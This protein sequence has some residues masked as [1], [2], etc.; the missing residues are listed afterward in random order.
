MSQISQ[1]LSWQKV[2]TQSSVKPPRSSGHSLTRVADKL[3]LFG[4]CSAAKDSSTV[5]AGT[6]NAV[7]VFDY[8]SKQWSMPKF[9]SGE[10]PPPRWHHTASAVNRMVVV[11]GGFKDNSHRYNDVWVFDTHSYKWSQP[12]KLR[13]ESEINP[14]S[15]LRNK[16]S[17]VPLPRGEHAAAVLGKKVYIF[18]GYGVRLGQ[19]ATTMISTPLTQRRGRGK[20]SQV[21]LPQRLNEKRRTGHLATP[22]RKRNG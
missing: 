13:S 22:T 16:L 3:F 21:A 15:S 5:S 12:I 1:T 7:Y 6:S 14:D 9:S 8:S 4:G 20:G 11:F 18:G 19:G 2:K 17:P 10:K